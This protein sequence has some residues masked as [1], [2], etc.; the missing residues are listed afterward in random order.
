MD[1]ERQEQLIRLLLPA[2]FVLG[3]LMVGWILT[4]FFVQELE[5]GESVLLK[6]FIIGLVFG[7]VAVILYFFSLGWAV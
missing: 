2:F 3:G 5:P 1:V 4:L 7:L 6:W